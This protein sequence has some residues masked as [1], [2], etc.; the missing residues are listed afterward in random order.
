[1]SRTII[2]AFRAID[3]E[4]F[5]AYTAQAAELGATHIVITE[6]IPR[7]FWQFD[8]P[9]DPY[10]AWF[11]HQP[12]LLK[13]FPPAPA[14]AHVDLRYAETV[15]RLFERRCAI[16]RSSGLKAF[17]WTNEPQI[18]PESFYRRHPECRGPRVDHPH[19]SRTARFAPCT[20]DP[21]VRA[22]YREA[23]Q[24][25]LQRCPEVEIFSFLTTD[26]GSGFCWAESLYPG[27]NGNPRC[28]HR[29]MGERVSGFLLSLR[30][31]AAEINHEIAIDIKEIEPRRWMKRTFDNPEGI[32][33]T[34]PPGT[35]VNHVEGSGG[36]AFVTR[37]FMGLH[38]HF[39]YPIV[40]VPRPVQFMQQLAEDE[41]KPDARQLVAF[42][43]PA[44]T[45][46][47]F[48]VWESYRQRRPTTELERLGALRAVATQEVGDERA[49]DLLSA[50]LRVEEA[51]GLLRTLNFGPIFR[52]GGLLS[53]WFTRPLVPFPGELSYEEKSHYRPYLF[54]AKT[55]AEAD[56]LIDIQAM[57]MFEGWGARLLTQNVMDQVRAKTA[58]ARGLVRELGPVVLDARLQVLDHFCRTVSNVVA[59]QAQ[60]DRLQSA[61]AKA[62]CVPVLGDGGDWARG[63][64]LSIARDELSNAVDLKRLLESYPNELVDTAESPEHETSL[65]LGPKLPHQIQRKIDV[66]N[67]HWTDYDRLRT[68]PNP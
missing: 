9:G 54:Q 16:L 62:E 58:V 8:T 67:A 63:D 15:A 66:M 11:S 68:A 18:L 43:D 19:R 35:A 37:E 5:A 38:W 31:A 28:A 56:N 27:K 7:S 49:D 53:R 45:D 39:L 57:R 22:L 12:G 60:L 30:E 29:T 3:E 10:P 13:I 61:D 65:Q 55:E 2:C 48:R 33:R 34:L 32:A 64:L 26:S 1:V 6:D 41:D 36:G 51:V 4:A 20:D 46:L 17:Y 24:S 23:M 40:G 47:S 52:M 44:N 59:Y 21:T 25:L 14:R 42:S 50:W